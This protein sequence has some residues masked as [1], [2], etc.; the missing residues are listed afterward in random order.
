MARQL[1]RTKADYK[2]SILINL[3]FQKP[4]YICHTGFPALQ[5]SKEGHFLKAQEPQTIL[6]TWG[7]E[8]T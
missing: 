1:Y 3:A 7:E 2:E 6:G 5:V 4:A 8:F